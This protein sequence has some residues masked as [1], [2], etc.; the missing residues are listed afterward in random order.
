MAPPIRQYQSWGQQAAQNGPDPV[1][2]IGRIV[3]APARVAVKA[4]QATGPQPKKTA[5]TF[6]GAADAAVKAAAGRARSAPKTVTTPRV[7]KPAVKRTVPAQLP[8]TSGKTTVPSRSVQTPDTTPTAAVAP[9]KQAKPVVA[10]AVA[11]KPKPP[12]A[13]QPAATTTPAAAQPSLQ[14]LA[15]Q[16]VQQE[17][18]GQYQQETQSNTA[19]NQAMQRFTT[20]LMQAVAP[21][22]G[23]IS[24]DY[25]SAAGQVGSLATAAANSLRAANPNDQEQQLLQ[26]VGAPDSQQQQIAGQLSNTF[27]GGAAVG[28]YLNGVLPVTGLEAQRLADATVARSLPAIEGLRGQQ[29][30]ALQ[31]YNDAQARQKIAAQGPALLQ[32]ALSALTSAQAKQD[33]LNIERA[34]LGIKQQNQN[35]AQTL[36]TAKYNQASAKLTAANSK[37]DPSV[38]KI[39]GY[40][41]TANGA[42]ITKGGKIITVDA[43]GKQSAPK[44]PTG[45]Q[46][47][48]LVSQWHDGKVGSVT[49][50]AVDKDGNPVYN[51]D[52]SQKYQSKSVQVGK[53]DF[54]QAYQRLRAMGLTDVKARQYLDTA[55][56][57]GDS[58]RAWLTNEEQAALRRAGL[59]PKATKMAGKAV[60]NQKQTAALRKVG[61]LPP[62]QLTQEGFYVIQAGF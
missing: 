13:R 42:P 53:V 50:P 58:G 60:L 41:A 48:S 4:L 51:P 20:Q 22:G 32:S 19:A 7:P 21:I 9:A 8:S 40:A 39:L 5:G 3:T 47:N 56:P 34:S 27:N 23:Q 62:G 44:L 1:Q 61:K 28:Q 33:Q 31:G 6:P 36:A 24:Q 38:S 2:S 49:V 59:Q 35:F 26:A 15:N 10:K 52:G 46:I 16:M 25:Q 45:T 57:R 30:L 55:Y 43:A 54:Q 29:A 37:I 12:V 18:A 14:Q 11:P 17:L